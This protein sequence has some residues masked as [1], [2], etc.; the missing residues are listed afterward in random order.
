MK[1]KKFV[2]IYLRIIKNV[3]IFWI[4]LSNSNIISEKNLDKRLFFINCIEYYA[5]KTLLII[6]Q[7]LWR[8]LKF[9]RNEIFISIDLIVIFNEIFEFRI[10]LAVFWNA[11]K[12]YLFISC[13]RD[14]RTYSSPIKR[15]FGSRYILGENQYYICEKVKKTLTN[16]I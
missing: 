6:F 13:L 5:P 14:A 7:K 4:K 3:I 16:T 12:M 15:N 9:F 1:I 11:K 8:F 10:S 2:K